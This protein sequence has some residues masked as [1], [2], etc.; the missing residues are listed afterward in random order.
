VTKTNSPS[1]ATHGD[2]TQVNNAKLSALKGLPHV[3]VAVNWGEEFDLAPV[4]AAP[5]RYDFLDLM[6]VLLILVETMQTLSDV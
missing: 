5:W 2:P 3:F 6:I 1:T 4:Q